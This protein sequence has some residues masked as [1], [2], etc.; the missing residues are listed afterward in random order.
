MAD[1]RPISSFKTHIKFS[2]RLIPK[3]STSLTID[4]SLK[5][6]ILG[7]DMHPEIQLQLQLHWRQRGS[8]IRENW[9]LWLADDIEK[10]SPP[11]LLLSFCPGDH[12]HHAFL[13]WRTGNGTSRS[14]YHHRS[15]TEKS[16]D[17]ITE[18][19]F[20]WRTLADGDGISIFGGRYVWI[21]ACPSQYQA[22]PPYISMRKQ[23]APSGRYHLRFWK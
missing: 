5:E 4:P 1:I 7:F 20:L 22:K 13:T 11:R 17:R 10:R 21:D 23:S 9:W 18:K 6:E 2:I 8:R 15:V 3:S 14:H 12:L 19:G 16:R